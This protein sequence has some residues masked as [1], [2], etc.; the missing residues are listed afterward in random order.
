LS[1]PPGGSRAARRRDHRVGRRERPDEAG[2]AGGQET[3]S[4]ETGGQE[5]GEARLI[6]CHL[7]PEWFEA[8]A[9]PNNCAIRLIE[10]GADQGYVFEGF[11]RS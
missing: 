1:A 10:N 5:T 6:G 7:S 3:G 4:Q 2:E 8:E 11:G 9:N